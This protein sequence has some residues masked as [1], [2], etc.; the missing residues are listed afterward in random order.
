MREEAE[1]KNREKDEVGKREGCK[2]GWGR[3][4]VGHGVLKI[5]RAFTHWRLVK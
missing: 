4:N 2:K 3:N 5:R 1:G